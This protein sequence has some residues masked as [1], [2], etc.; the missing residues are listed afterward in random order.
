MTL[1]T[2][3][4]S[5]IGFTV[6]R[7]DSQWVPFE[8]RMFYCR[9]PNDLERSI[10]YREWASDCV[11]LMSQFGFNY[12]FRKMKVGERRRYFAHAEFS[13]YQDYWGESDYDMEILKMRR[14]K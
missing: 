14:V 1:V 9:Q 8:Y 12:I 10:Y 5:R 3:Q 2:S 4:I 7:F 13:H 11:G 6:E